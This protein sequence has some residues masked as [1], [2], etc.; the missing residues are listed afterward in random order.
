MTT[1]ELHN[2]KEEQE[3]CTVCGKEKSVYL[4]YGHELCKSCYYTI[5]NGMNEAL[6]RM[7]DEEA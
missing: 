2:K 5:N 7:Q 4:A 6:R 3:L 1:S